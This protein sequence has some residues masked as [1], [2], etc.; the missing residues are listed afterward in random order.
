MFLLALTDSVNTLGYLKVE[1]NLVHSST[2]RVRELNS[3]SG[4][5]AMISGSE[6]AL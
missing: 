5:L 6:L 4:R 2:P 3:G 1:G